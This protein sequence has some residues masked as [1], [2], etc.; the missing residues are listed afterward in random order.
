MK[1]GDICIHCNHDDNPETAAQNWKKRCVKINYDNLFIEMYT[2]STKIADQFQAIEQFEK[3][4]CFVPF[5]SK[6][7]N[8]FKLVLHGNQTEFWQAVNSNGGNGNNC[9]TYDIIGLLNMKFR[10]RGI[11]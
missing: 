6:N 2:E 7:K 1:I 3:R 4:I 10:Y 5:E 11:Q 8:A 9:F